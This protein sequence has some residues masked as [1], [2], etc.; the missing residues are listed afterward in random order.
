MS[1]VPYEELPEHP[2]ETVVGKV[3]GILL[4]GAVFVCLPPVIVDVGEHD[5]PIPLNVRAMRIPL[6]VGEVVV[7][8]VD[9]HLLPR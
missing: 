7:L 1:P 8:A 4:Q 6:H 2:A 9:G 3:G 5:L